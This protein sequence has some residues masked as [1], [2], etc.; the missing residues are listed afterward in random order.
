[1]SAF[2]KFLKCLGFTT[3][4]INVTIVIIVVICDDGHQGKQ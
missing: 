3:K 2:M 4:D 1:M